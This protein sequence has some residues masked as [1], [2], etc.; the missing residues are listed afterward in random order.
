[1]MRKRAPTIEEI[2]KLNSRFA[3][4]NIQELSSL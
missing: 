3:E 4:D 2:M 1:M